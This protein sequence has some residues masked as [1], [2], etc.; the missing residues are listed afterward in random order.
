MMHDGG[1]EGDFPAKVGWTSILVY[2]L[3]GH[4]Q[5]LH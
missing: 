5:A 1:Y 4:S 3:A 2:D